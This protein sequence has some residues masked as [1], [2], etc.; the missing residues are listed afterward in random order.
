MILGYNTNGLAHH[1]LSDA[2]ELLASIGYRG[3]AVTLDHGALNPYSHG[4]ESQADKLRGLAAEYDLTLVVETG[5]RF[6][7][8]PRQ[9]HE[10]TLVSPDPQ[11][12]ARRVEFLKRAIDTA[13]LIGAHCVS[14]WS[15]A[16]RDAATDQVAISR[17]IDGLLPVLRHAHMKEVTLAFEPEPGMLVETL[18][19]WFDVKAQIAQAGPSLTPPH[20]TVDIG[21]LHCNAET[22]IADQIRNCGPEITNIHVEDMLAGKHEHLMFGEGEIEF[23]PIIEALHQIGYAGPINVELSRHSHDG[24]RAAQQAYDFLSPLIARYA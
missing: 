12:R 1:E 18:Q 15:G 3:V 5:A 10:P 22:P 17:L 7:L 8:D 13:K 16:V 14:L 19:D 11:P 20:V 21:H 23:P 4:Y 2:V 6:L 9:K 24:V